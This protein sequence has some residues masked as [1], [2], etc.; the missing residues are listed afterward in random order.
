MSSTSEK[1]LRQRVVRAAE[2]LLA[3]KGY[4]APIEVW[5]EIRWFNSENLEHWRRGSR[6]SLDWPAGIPAVNI[7]LSV[8]FLAEWARS[9]GLAASEVEYL[10]ATRD[11]HPLT[12][13][14]QKDPSVELACR[15]HWMSGDIPDVKRDRM[16]A[17]QSKAPDL[18]V[19]WPKK[20]F[21]CGD[22]GAADQT[23]TLVKEGEDAL[24]AECADLDHLIYLPRGNTALTRRARKESTLSAIVVEWSRQRKR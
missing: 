2:S 8:E 7:A 14:S 3:Q 5:K 15:T 12:F 18:V 20:P 4:V 17:A 13:L 1:K 10:S 23:G 19:F 11:H 22:C 16:T 6:A 9:K 21:T 24:C